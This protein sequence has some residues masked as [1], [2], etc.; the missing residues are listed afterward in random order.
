MRAQPM[1]FTSRWLEPK[2]LMEFIDNRVKQTS[3]LRK[4]QDMVT[5]FKSF[6]M[7]ESRKTSSI[8]SDAI[9]ANAIKTISLTVQAHLF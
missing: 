9:K 3:T 6:R 8:H 4:T 7:K 5:F 1:S 2:S